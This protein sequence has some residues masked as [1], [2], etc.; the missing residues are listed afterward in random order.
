M[1][2]VKWGVGPCRGQRV[3]GTQTGCDASAHPAEHPRAVNKGNFVVTWLSLGLSG[4]AGL[5]WHCWPLSIPPQSW[6]SGSRS[7]TVSRA[8]S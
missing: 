5:C 4:D 6:G 3:R 7:P 8:G 1:L 2:G